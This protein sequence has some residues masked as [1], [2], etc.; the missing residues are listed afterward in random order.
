MADIK[1]DVIQYLINDLEKYSLYW[2]GASKDEYYNYSSL[3]SYKDGDKLGFQE[4][5]NRIKDQSIS[6]LYKAQRES[7]SSSSND[8]YKYG[9]EDDNDF[10]GDSNNTNSSNNSSNKNNNSN[11]N[12]YNNNNNNKKNYKYKKYVG[13]YYN[14]EDIDRII[15][16]NY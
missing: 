1:D 9:Y 15:I 8:S 6:D 4:I 12:N 10:S 3:Y 13:Y 7:A 16:F 2:S 11:N 14:G 5:R